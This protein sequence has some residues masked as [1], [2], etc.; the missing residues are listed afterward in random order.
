MRQ[1]AL[2]EASEVSTAQRAEILARVDAAVA[3][4]PERYRRV[5]VLCYL[6]GASQSEAAERLR[7]SPGTVAARCSRGLERL[8]ARL[9]IAEDRRLGASALGVL[10]SDEAA[11][12][13]QVFS[14][15]PAL[16]S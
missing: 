13:A 14:L 4:L 2:T 1:P 10:L 16:S 12:A 15:K 11:R 9:G 7:L 8:R 5:L 3:A 6:E